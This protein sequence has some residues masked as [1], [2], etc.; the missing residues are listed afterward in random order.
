MTTSTVVPDRVFDLT[1][2][3]QDALAHGT[4]F[5][6]AAAA[7]A[8]SPTPERVE[9]LGRTIGWFEGSFIRHMAREDAAVIPVLETVVGQ[10]C[11]LPAWMRRDHDDLRAAIRDARAAV[12]TA[13]RDPGAAAPDLRRQADRL[14]SLLAIH[15]HREDQW[16]M[17]VARAM[18]TQE[19]WDEIDRQLG[20][21]RA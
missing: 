13:R 12:R 6:D 1:N 10:W 5:F 11:A 20:R 8:E 7:F 18:L 14:R 9:D 17:P 15:F 19:Q 4:A 3:H 2:D 21:I 16:L